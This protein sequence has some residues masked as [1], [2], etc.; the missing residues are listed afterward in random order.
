[1]KDSKQQAHYTP[2][3]MKPHENCGRCKYYHRLNGYIGECD[4]VM[5][6]VAQAGW[7]KWWSR[8]DV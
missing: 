3:A 2:V 1:M 8:K 6:T 5:G 7:C 4:K